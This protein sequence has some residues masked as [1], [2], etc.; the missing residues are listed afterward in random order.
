MAKKI[1][2]NSY[3]KAYQDLDFLRSDEARSV[4]LLLEMLKPQV[5]LY[6]SKVKDG[7]VCFGSARINEK[8]IAVNHVKYLEEKLKKT[9]KIPV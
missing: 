4:R 7:V 3:T 2:Y 1:T 6:H 9:P 5:M 8:P